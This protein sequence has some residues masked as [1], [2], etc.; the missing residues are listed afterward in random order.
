ML[1]GIVNKDGVLYYYENGNPKERFLFEYEGAYYYSRYNGAL[2]V[3]NKYYAYKVDASCD[4]PV[5]HYEFG[6]DG[7]MLQGIVE[8]DGVLYFYENGNPVEKGLFEYEGNYYY[9][10]YN[11]ALVVDGKYYAYKVDAD[12]D[13]P[14]GH[15]EFGADGKMLDGIIE[16][17]G[18]KYYYENGQ[19]VEKGLFIMDGYY[20]YA[21]YDGK[22]ITNQTYYVYKTNDLLF[23]KN[24]IFNEL[25]QII[26]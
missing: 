2:V 10:R 24:Y 15:Y 11:G 1:N 26:G 6:A 5:G 19:T 3:N 9:T 13:L 25:G 7:K 22:I 4:L 23:A 12:C 14:V 18:V 16:K 20:Y 8:K 21:R 17:N